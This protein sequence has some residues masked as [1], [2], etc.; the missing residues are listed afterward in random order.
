MKDDDKIKSLSEYQ[1]KKQ[2]KLDH[3]YLVEI[4]E[5]TEP[6]QSHNEINENEK[7]RIQLSVH[8]MSQVCGWVLS[9]HVVMR[10]GVKLVFD[11]PDYLERKELMI[12]T[13]EQNQFVVKTRNKDF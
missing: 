5:V 8:N 6:K 11:H 13:D 12:H 4:A 3:H 7:Q 9:D 1:L 10:N 2:L